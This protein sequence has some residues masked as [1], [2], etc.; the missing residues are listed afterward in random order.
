MHTCCEIMRW[1]TARGEKS[2]SL[3]RGSEGGAMCR[4]GRF[5]A[6]DY[7]GACQGFPDGMQRMGAIP[8]RHNGF[9]KKGWA[10]LA[11]VL[12]EGLPQHIMEVFTRDVGIL[13]V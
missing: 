11:P 2:N 9:G 3:R 1:Y 4:E 8:P 12:P 6:L 10:E 7:A 5:D 13:D